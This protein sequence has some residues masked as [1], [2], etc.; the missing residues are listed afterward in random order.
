MILIT[1]AAGKTGRAVLKALVNKKAVVRVLAHRR[2]QIA[3]LLAAGATEVLAGDLNKAETFRIAFSDITSLYHICPNMHPDE[4]E[5]GKMAI[6]TAKKV[7]IQHFVYHSVLHPQAEKMP[8]HWSKLRVE[9]MLFES[10]L[11]FT[12]LQPAPYMQNILA[13]KEKILNEGYYSAPYPV[14]TAL[15]LIDLEDLGEA[16]AVVL[17]EEGY[18]NAVYE[19]SG[20]AATAQDELVAAL[21]VALGKE[22]SYREINLADWRKA[23][24]DQ[25]VDQYGIDTLLRMFKYY[26][27]YGL[28]GNKKILQWLLGREPHSL[29]D[30]INR[31]ILPGEALT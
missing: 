27:T 2:E 7:G 21:S 1:G 10:G 4:I 23:A 31:E 22:I 16:A 25:G 29:I 20:T 3:E 18:G 6:T 17:T 24:A 11:D 28:M 19:L 26:A 8:H 14:A 5:I 15:S 30:F 9:E 12:I 13:G